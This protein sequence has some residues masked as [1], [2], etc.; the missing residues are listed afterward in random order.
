M[1][2]R[3][4][5]QAERCAA[6]ALKL[7]PGW[8]ASLR[9]LGRA[10]CGAGHFEAGVQCLHEA[11]RQEPACVEG[12]RE[13]AE[14]LQ[15]HGRTSDALSAYVHATTLAPEH[16]ETAMVLADCAETVGHSALAREAIDD[17]GVGARVAVVAFDDRASVA[18]EPGGAGEARAALET[19]RPSYGATRYAAAISKAA[20]LASGGPARVIVR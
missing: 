8:S 10:R 1:E 15:A 18:A 20:E 3:N 17:A 2:Q 9:L 16:V 11:L 14:L 13:L 12:W 19:I 6:D 7:R 4:W 5:T